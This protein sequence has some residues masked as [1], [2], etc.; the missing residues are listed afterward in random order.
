M[1]TTL[2]GVVGLTPPSGIPT[3][4]CDRPG[5]VGWDCLQRTGRQPVSRP[6]R[7]CLP[8]PRARRL[9]AV[10]SFISSRS[11]LPRTPPCRRADARPPARLLFPRLT[12]D[13]QR[14]LDTGSM[15][16]NTGRLGQGPFPSSGQEPVPAY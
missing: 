6:V 14:G 5:P 13:A 7:I 10:C 16:R 12:A 15:R 8:R 1:V 11:W 3:G 9:A 4:S 2:G